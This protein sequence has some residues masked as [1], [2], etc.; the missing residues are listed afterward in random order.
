MRRVAIKYLFVAQLGSPQESEWTELQTVQTII[1]NLRISGDSRLV[2]SLLRNILEEQRS[3]KK[4]V[5]R[6]GRKSKVPL[7]SPQADLIYRSLSAGMSTLSTTILLNK[8]RVDIRKDTVSLSAVQ[9]FIL[10]SD[11]I[12]RSRRLSTKS[13][14]KDVG[15]PWAKARLNQ[16]LQ[17]QHQ[18]AYGD[19][20]EHGIPFC[21][22][23][24]YA[25][26]APMH[27]DAIVWWDEHHR[28]VILGHV[29]K[30]ENR[31]ALKD[32]VATAI[33][34]SGILSAKMH[35]TVTK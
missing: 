28:K 1:R 22:P 11:I 10:R 9:G 34:E 15:S 33:A 21:V 4:P 16:F 3:G 31:V 24:Q 26:A 2:K 19:S 32:G 17:F 13:G 29:P 7:D 27:L 20:K 23:P 18:L 35:N 25:D 5:E 12:D 30:F 6:R 8:Y 14:K